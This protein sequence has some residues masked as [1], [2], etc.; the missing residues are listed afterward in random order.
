M[1]RP[2]RFS[3]L[4]SLAEFFLDR[5]SAGK[6]AHLPI[7]EERLHFVLA[8]AIQNHGR[9]GHLSV[10]EQD[11]TIQGAILGG[12]S[13]LYLVTE[14][15]EATDLAWIVAPGASPRAGAALL[16]AFDDWAWSNPAVVRVKHGV[17]DTMGIVHPA[18][19]RLLERQGF[20][21]T[22]GIYEKDRQL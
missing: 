6:M 20:S 14:A 18:A 7:N 16:K 19:V 4:P 1:L 9:A 12:L 17:C 11:G 15:L 3:D 13:P 21:L 8:T 5:W 2:G 10:W 22:G